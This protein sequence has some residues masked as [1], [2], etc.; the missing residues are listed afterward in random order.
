MTLNEGITLSSDLSSLIFIPCISLG[1]L[2]KSY[3][4]SLAAT[5]DV[6]ADILRALALPG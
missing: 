5:L 4:P 6:L 1:K 3:F 2:T